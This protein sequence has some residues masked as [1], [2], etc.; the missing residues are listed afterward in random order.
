MKMKWTQYHDKE[1]LKL[2]YKVKEEGIKGK[3][4]K[5]IVEEFKKN[6]KQFTC[7]IASILMKVSNF[8]WLDT[9]KGLKNASKQSGQIYNKYKKK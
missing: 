9:G 1:V 5:K 3:E 6:N 7:P 2:Y 4:L 8:R